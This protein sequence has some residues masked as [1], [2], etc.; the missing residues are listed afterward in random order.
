MAWNLF[1][2]LV[3]F[4]LS[5]LFFRGS[6][7]K[8]GVVLIFP[9]VNVVARVTLAA[10][11]LVLAPCAIFRRT[12]MFSAIGLQAASYVFATTTW[13]FAFMVLSALWRLPGVIAGVVLG[14]VGVIPL[15]LIAAISKGLWQPEAE[16]ISLGLMVTIGAY[17]AAT[18]VA[19]KL[20][21]PF[22]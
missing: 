5:V 22:I 19:G 21:R 9:V 11:V 12:R 7:S 8:W 10:C 2:I 18:F 1:V 13:L 20:D 16:L 3:L 4:L 14:V 6:M 15:A 17:I